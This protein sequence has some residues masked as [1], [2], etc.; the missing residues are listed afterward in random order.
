[1][2]NKKTDDMKKYRKDYYANNKDKV[3]DYNRMWCENNPDYYKNYARGMRQS[4]WTCPKV[5][6]NICGFITHKNNLTRHQASKKCIAISQGFKGYSKYNPKPQQ[7][8][9]QK[10]EQEELAVS[11]VLP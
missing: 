11:P 9:E 5:T 7:T 1:M 2:S 6:C 4:G 10:E 3:K 8:E